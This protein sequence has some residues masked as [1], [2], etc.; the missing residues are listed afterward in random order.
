MGTAA[1]AAEYVGKRLR[2]A[3]RGLAHQ[4]ARSMRWMIERGVPR[5]VAASTLWIAK[6]AVLAAFMYVAFWFALVL[7]IVLIAATAAKRAHHV[8]SGACSYDE[9]V[10]RPAWEKGEPTDHR[11][12]LF[13][14]PL[15]YADDPD[16]RFE[17]DQQHR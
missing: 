12:R 8:D 5:L 6:L 15:P 10:A 2:R 9:D 11:Q 17:G 3:W 16:P 4:E 1:T 7:A 13:Y 14:D